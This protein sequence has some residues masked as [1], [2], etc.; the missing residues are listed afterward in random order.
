MG[1]TNFVEDG[2]N[3]RA[4]KYLQQAA[5]QR[6]DDVQL[7]Y[8]LSGAYALTGDYQK[9]YDTIVKAEKIDPKFPDLQNFK[10]QL[11]RVLQENNE[12]QKAS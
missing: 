10:H 3:P 6:P 8:N 11:E 1:R 5:R 7:L 9:A 2:A 12:P 4:L